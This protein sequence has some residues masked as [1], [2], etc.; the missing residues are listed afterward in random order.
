MLQLCVA[1]NRP[2]CHSP[3]VSELMG[4]P[5]VRATD[6]GKSQI[7]G[8]I[9]QLHSS[10]T[11]CEEFEISRPVDTDTWVHTAHPK[12]NISINCYKPQLLAA[13]ITFSKKILLPRTENKQIQNKIRW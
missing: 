11:S 12:I 7:L 8:R 9:E 6:G 1:M 4:R 2:P 5:R 13:A 10:F 3:L